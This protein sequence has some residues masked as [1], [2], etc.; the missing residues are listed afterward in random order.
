MVLT[1]GAGGV[2]AFA[3]EGGRVHVAAPVVEVADT[4]GAGDAAM[5]ALLTKLQAIGVDGV[6][7]DLESVLR[8]V[9]AVAALACTRPG[10]YAPTAADVAAA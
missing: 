10:A 6:T 5:G 9:C 4:I 1:R 3:R 2:T 7:K 8:Y